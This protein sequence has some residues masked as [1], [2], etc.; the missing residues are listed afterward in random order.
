MVNDKWLMKKL[1]S[2]ANFFA[3]LLFFYHSYK[4]YEPDKL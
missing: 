1:M 3:L 4:L 2:F